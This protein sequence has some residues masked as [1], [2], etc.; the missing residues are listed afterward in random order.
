MGGL[1]FRGQYAPTLTQEELESKVNVQY[2]YHS[3]F[4]DLSV[5]EQAERHQWIMDRVVNRLFIHHFIDRHVD[6]AK[7]RVTVYI[8][9]SQQYAQLSPRAKDAR[10][11]V[12]YE[13]PPPNQGSIIPLGQM[14]LAGMQDP[15]SGPS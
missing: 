14:G 12:S 1:P 7:G 6:H 11:G 2:D 15:S 5:P 3:E 9:W 10:S 4:F 8:E 13:L